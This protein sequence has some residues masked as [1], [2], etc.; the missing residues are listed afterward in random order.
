MSGASKN[1]KVLIAEDDKNLC[2]FYSTAFMKKGFQ[3]YTAQDGEAALDKY[4]NKEPDIVL[5]DTAMPDMNGYEVLGEIRKNVTSYTPVIM[6]TGFDSQ[7]E[8]QQAHLDAFDALLVKSEHT[9]SEIVEKT[10][11]VLS[12]NRLV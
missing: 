6:I 7:S 9:P 1:I 2:E 8:V 10:E 12:L 5:L 11:E 4:K 3:V